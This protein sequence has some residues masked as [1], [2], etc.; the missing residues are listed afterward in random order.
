MRNEARGDHAH[1]STQFVR[2]ADFMQGRKDES[3]VAPGANRCNGFRDMPPVHDAFAPEMHDVA[4]VGVNKAKPSPSRRPHGSFAVVSH[5]W[6][7][8]F[9][10]QLAILPEVDLDSSDLRLVTVPRGYRS[11]FVPPRGTG[12]GVGMVREGAASPPL[13]RNFTVDESGVA[14]WS[15]QPP[16]SSQVNMNTV[17]SYSAPRTTASTAAKTASRPMVTSAGGCYQ[18]G[19]HA[20]RKTARA[21]CPLQHR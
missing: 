19:W 5:C 8:L 7:D 17:S 12:F 10:L 1:P 6:C 21:G 3:A 11:S 13:G 4:H 18:L 9:S 14:T 16:Q 15:S 2:N 20:T